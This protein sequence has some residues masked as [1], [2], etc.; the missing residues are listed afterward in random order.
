M[1]IM[2]WLAPMY[3]LIS[4]FGEDQ[5]NYMLRVFVQQ[6]R[7]VRLMFNLNHKESCKGTFIK[8]KILTARIYIYK[9]LIFAKNNLQ[10]F[11]TL[12]NNHDYNTRHGKLLSI[13]K[14]KTAKFKES[15][16]YNSIILYNALN[17]RS[18]KFTTCKI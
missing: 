14:H 11:K 9:C 12:D 13:P 4:V 8:K 16:H 15:L 3:R 7:I 18:P 10:E 6:K 5:A 17:W 1:F 2:H